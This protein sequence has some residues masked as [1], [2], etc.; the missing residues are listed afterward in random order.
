M[1]TGQA[2]TDPLEAVKRAGV[3]RVEEW[4][5]M[6]AEYKNSSITLG[7]IDSAASTMQSVTSGVEKMSMGRNSAGHAS[8]NGAAYVSLPFSLSFFTAMRMLRLFSC[9]GLSQSER[10]QSVP[11]S[12]PVAAADAESPSASGRSGSRIHS[13]VLLR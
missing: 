12:T 3:P 10:E 8:Q 1:Q 6:T 9:T 5:K 11:T 13:P 2:V 7:K 4:K